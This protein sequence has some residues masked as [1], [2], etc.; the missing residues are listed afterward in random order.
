LEPGP[1]T[2]ILIK[3]SVL[4]FSSKLTKRWIAYKWVGLELGLELGL[5]RMDLLELGLVWFGL[6]WLG[7]ELGLG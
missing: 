3:G 5:G 1:W 2:L 4:G 7:L 6:A